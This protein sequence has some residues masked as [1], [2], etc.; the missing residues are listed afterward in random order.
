M[1]N[2]R[3]VDWQRFFVKH[4][5]TRTICQ[6]CHREI[7]IYHMKVK[8]IARD[9]ERK[10]LGLEDESVTDSDMQDEIMDEN[11][12]N[13]EG[14]R[15]KIRLISDGAKEVIRKWIGIARDNLGDKG[16]AKQKDFDGP[17]GNY[18]LKNNNDD[19]DQDEEQKVEDN[20]Y[21]EDDFEQESGG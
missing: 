13:V 3:I 10:K 9:R 2:Y 19:G 11:G 5:S 4:A 1:I 17:D 7:E 8:K 20:Y 18:L 14:R 12:V 6:D 21:Y 15:K 16:A